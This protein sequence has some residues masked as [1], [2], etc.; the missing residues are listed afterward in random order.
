[1]QSINEKTTMLK[2]S[3]TIQLMK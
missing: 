1:M 3:N 2:C